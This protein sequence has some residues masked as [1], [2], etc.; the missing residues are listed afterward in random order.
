MEGSGVKLVSLADYAEDN[1]VLKA[2]KWIKKDLY[3]NSV[4]DY[5]D[6]IDPVLNRTYE[7]RNIMEHRYLKVLDDSFLMGDEDDRIDE[8]ASPVTIK[9]FYDLAINLLRVCR[10]SMI[11][12]VMAI[13]IEE[14]KRGKSLDKKKFLA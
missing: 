1:Y 4:S 5:K 10:E 2:L 14:D 3:K 6:H 8:L 9:E 7:I 11:L 13:K 12:L